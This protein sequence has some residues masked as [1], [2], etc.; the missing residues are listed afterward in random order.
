MV[1]CLNSSY[2]KAVKIGEKVTFEA[3]V[4]RQGTSVTYAT[5]SVFNEKGELAAHGTH[6][7]HVGT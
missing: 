5:A 6:V 2:L 4:T 1:F 3:D 7:K